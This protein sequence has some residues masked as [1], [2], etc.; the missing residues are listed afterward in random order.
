MRDDAYIWHLKK[1]ESPKIQRK[2][3]WTGATLLFLDESFV[4]SEPNV[5]RTWW[6]EGRHPE[7]QVRQGNRMKL[8]LIS[9]VEFKGQLYF[10]ISPLNQNFN[11]G[12]VIEFLRYLL[13]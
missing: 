1:V 5:R 3:R 8:S 12:G 13:R 11:G 6:M 10:R 4:Q 7:I 9:A 2:T